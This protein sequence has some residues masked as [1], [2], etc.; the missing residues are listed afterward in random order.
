MGNSASSTTGYTLGA[1][2]AGTLV[3]GR[4]TSVAAITVTGGSHVI[5]ATVSLV[6]GLLVTPAAGATLTISGNISQ[7]G[8]S[9]L[10][11]GGSGTLVLGGS[12]TFSGGSTILAGT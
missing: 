4:S 6:N 7:T 11:L 1:G 5:S 8:A 2:S 9:G 3:L 12:N 10:T